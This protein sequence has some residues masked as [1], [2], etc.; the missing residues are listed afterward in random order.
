MSV[1]L[2]IIVINLD[3]VPDRMVAVR[4]QFTRANLNERVT[5]FSAVDAMLPGFSAPGYAPGSWRD[6]WTLLPSE[7]AVFA[8][9]RE[10]WQQVAEGPAPGAV[11][12]EDDI[13][14][15]DGFGAA[16]Q[17]LEIERFGV[18]KLDGFSAY[19]HYGPEI[20]MGEF[21]VRD[22]LDAV[23]SAACYAISKAAACRLL[24][25]SF[26]FCTTLDDFVFAAR[27]GLRP[28]QLF[29]AVA[30]QGMCCVSDQFVPEAIALSE[31]DTATIHA[32]ADKG[33]LLYRLRK[34]LKRASSK[35]ARTLGADR[36]LIRRGGVLCRP[37]L[38]D[39]LPDYVS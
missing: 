9:H 31:R 2:P 20:P 15:S 1:N 34:E 19:R 22:I 10:V 39:D 29:P 12:C 28:V 6:R 5:R 30:V 21:A 18:I 32:R 36:R 26:A 38:A 33:P 13:M 11:I 4:A 3:R 37:Q 25:D 7:Q 24:E 17:A 27:K 14:V 16:L 35:I 8:S 23:P